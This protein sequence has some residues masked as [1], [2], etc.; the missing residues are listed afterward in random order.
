MINKIFFAIYICILPCSVWGQKLW[1]F[2]E[3]V[4]Y[5]VEHSIDIKQQEIKMKNAE[6]AL[7][8]ARNN[9]LPNLN[10]GSGQ[11]LNFGRSQSQETG[12]YEN[13]QTSSISISA[14]SSI[15]L[16]SGFGLTNTIK[17]SKL[18]LLASMEGLKKAKN[19]LEVQIAFLYLDVLFK[20]EIIKIYES[21]FRQTLKQIE[22]TVILVETGKV[23]ETQLLDIKAQNARNEVEVINATNDLSMSLL[24][25]SQVLN[26]ENKGFD[27]VQPG[28][29]D[30]IIV[31]V[32]SLD[33]IYNEAMAIR[34]EV[35]E[36]QYN[37]ESG[38]KGVKVAQASGWPS[39]SLGLSYASGFSH[40]IKNIGDIDFE[41]TDPMKQLKNN[42]RQAIGLNLSFPI[43]NKYQVH[44]QIKLAKLTVDSRKLELDN[45]KLELFKEIQQAY[46]RVVAAKAKYIA[47]EKAVQASEKAFVYV[48]ERYE[49][50]KLTVYELSDAQ[51]KLIS[52]QSERLQAK[53]EY[54]FSTKILGFYRGKVMN[55]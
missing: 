34:P 42:Q 14:S 3:C 8:L 40:I 2:R 29:L 24:N 43:F 49:M 1:T 44:N 46:Q 45:V 33:F 41:E 32:L 51:M 15:P 22:R 35:R 11:S 28:F 16:F 30:D 21:Q 9:R 55:F 48:Q 10:A 12:I 36:A 39:L 4:D 19:N 5:A 54:L 18:N 23:S 17:Q 6:I 13:R 31:E 37:L 38:M 26:I 27:I 53:Y 52:T 25:L 47:T 7:S 50:G 20:K